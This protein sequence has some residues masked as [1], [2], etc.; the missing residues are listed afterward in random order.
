MKNHLS[1]ASLLLVF[2]MCLP[3]SDVYPASNSQSFIGT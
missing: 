3:A 2:A 1:L